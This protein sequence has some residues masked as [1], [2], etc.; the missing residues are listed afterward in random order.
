[1]KYIKYLIGIVALLFLVGCETD[2]DG[3]GGYGDRGGY[4]YGNRE[5]GYYGAERIHP[6][7]PGSYP[8]S[9][10]YWDRD[11]GRGPY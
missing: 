1:M 7:Y 9:Y 2:H 5:S 4:G 10:E 8:G 11:R 3:R 6:D